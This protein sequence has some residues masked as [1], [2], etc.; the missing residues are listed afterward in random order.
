MNPPLPVPWSDHFLVPFG[1]RLWGLKAQV[2]SKGETARRKWAGFSQEKFNNAL[3]QG[4]LPGGTDVESACGN[5]D[6]RITEALD[7]TAP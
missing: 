6:S 3:A 7:S 2:I 1:L 5:L 4:G